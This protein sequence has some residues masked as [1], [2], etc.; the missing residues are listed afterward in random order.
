MARLKTGALFRGACECGAILGGGPHWV[1]Q[2]A[3]YGENLGLAFQIRDD[4]LPYVSD[5]HVTGKGGTRRRC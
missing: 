3:A 2:L 1:S 4:L 5:S